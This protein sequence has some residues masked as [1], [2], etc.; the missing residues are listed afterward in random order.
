MQLHFRIEIIVPSE[1]YYYILFIYV[2]LKE[3]YWD[4]HAFHSHHS[5]CLEPGSLAGISFLLPTLS[6]S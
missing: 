1:I 2:P 6:L 4:E 3:G 5:F